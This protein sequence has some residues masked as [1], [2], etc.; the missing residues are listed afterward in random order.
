V[1]CAWRPKRH[2]HLLHEKKKEKSQAPKAWGHSSM[3]KEKEAR[4]SNKI[5]RRR[6]LLSPSRAMSFSFWL[7]EEVSFIFSRRIFFVVYP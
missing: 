1:C 7:V 5:R 6:P 4:V 3:V 2:Q